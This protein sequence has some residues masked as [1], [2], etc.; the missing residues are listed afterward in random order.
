MAARVSGY[1]ISGSAVKPFHEISTADAKHLQETWRTKAGDWQQWLR[2]HPSPQQPPPR[3][4]PCSGSNV[5]RKTNVGFSCSWSGVWQPMS[6]SQI[7]H[8]PL[9]DP[10]EKSDP[11]SGKVY[12]RPHSVSDTSGVDAWANYT[13][14]IN[15]HADWR[16]LPLETWSR[17]HTR[18]V[19]GRTLEIRKMPWQQHIIN[20]SECCGRCSAS[21]N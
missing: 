11:W 21:T 3:S 14:C 17:I 15:G 8:L 1:I 18:F 20:K 7:L 19:Q 9:H 5:Y 6:N 2:E 12:A 13:R 16:S 10:W 4:P